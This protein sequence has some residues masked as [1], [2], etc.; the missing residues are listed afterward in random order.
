MKT[1]QALIIKNQFCENLAYVNI[2]RWFFIVKLISTFCTLTLCIPIVWVLIVWGSWANVAQAE[3]EFRFERKWPQLEQPWFFSNPQGIATGPNDE[4]YVASY[5]GNKVDV[6]S[7]SGMFMYSWGTKMTYGGVPFKA[8][9]ITYGPDN[10]IWVGGEGYV[11]IFEKDGTFVKKFGVGYTSTTS[12]PNAF[13]RIYGLEFDSDMHLWLVDSANNRLLVFNVFDVN[14]SLL[15][16]F[17]SLNSFGSSGSGDGQFSSPTGINI[18]GDSV[19]VAERSNK[20]IQVINRLNGTYQKKFLNAIPGVSWGDDAYDVLVDTTDPDQSVW[21]VSNTG[22]KKFSSSG[23]LLSD[24]EGGPWPNQSSRHYYWAPYSIAKTS[25]GRL[26][27]ADSGY[28][29][30]VITDS[31]G[32]LQKTVGSSDVKNGYFWKTTDVATFANGDVVVVDSGNHRLQVFAADGSFKKIIGGYGSSCCGNSNYGKF[33]VPQGVAISPINQHIWVA[34]N[35]NYRI[36]EFDSNGTFL[37]AFTAGASNMGPMGIAI[38]GDG[39]VWSTLT[40]Q[41][42]VVVYNTSG[43]LIASINTLGTDS[44]Y[45]PQKFRNPWGIAVAPNGDIWVTEEYN[46]YWDTHYGL[47]RLRLTADGI[48]VIGKYAAYGISA[49]QTNRARGVTVDNNGLVYVGDTYNHRIQQFDPASETWRILFNKTDVSPMSNEGGFNYLEGLEFDTN[50]MLYVAD[51]DNHRIQIIKPINNPDHS[52]AIVVAAGGTDSSNELWPATQ[53]NANYAYRTFR[54]QGYTKDEIRYLSSNTQQD[55]DFNG[56]MDDIVGLPT[57]VNIENA[58]NTWTTQSDTDNLVLY[59]VDH[60]GDGSFRL[61]NTETLTAAELDGWLDQLETSIQ[62]LQRI[63]IIIDACE[64]GSFIKGSGLATLAGSKR[65]II[66]SAQPLQNA[67]FLTQGTVS[68]SNYFWAHIFHGNDLRSAFDHASE[69]MAAYQVPQVDFNGNGIS[70]EGEDLSLLNNQYIGNGIGASSSAPLIA[71]TQA[72]PAILTATGGSSVIT[73]NITDGDGILD[74]YAIVRSPDFDPGSASQTITELPKIPLRYNSQTQHFESNGYWNTDAQGQYRFNQGAY[75]FNKPGTYVLTLYAEDNNYNAADPKQLTVT[76]DTG[77]HRRA[78]II[79]GYGAGT[80]LSASFRDNAKL[81]HDTLIRQGYSE[82]NIYYLSGSGLPGVDATPTA[83]NVQ[84]A[85]TQ[86]GMD[87]NTDNTEDLAVYLIA[88]RAQLNDQPG[89][90]LSTLDNGNTFESITLSQLALW[91][92][93]RQSSNGF[94]QSTGLPYSGTITV[95]LD[96]CYSGE[97]LATLNPNKQRRI[98]ISSSTPEG[99]AHFTNHTLLSGQTFSTE[100]SFSRV[101]WQKIQHGANLRDAFS[102]AGNAVNLITGVQTPQLDDNFNGL[103]NDAGQLDAQGNVTLAKDGDAARKMS[104]GYGIFAAE[105]QPRILE[106]T[107]SGNIQTL[108][109][110][111][112]MQVAST[113]AISDAWAV[114]TRPDYSP[115]CSA[116]DQLPKLHLSKDSNN[117]A[118]WSAD[119]SK[120]DVNGDYKITFYAIDQNTQQSQPA[121][122]VLNRSAAPEITEGG[123]NSGMLEPNNSLN[124]ASFSLVNDR[125]KTLALE[126]AD[127]QDWIGFYAQQGQT[128]TIEAKNVGADI[129]LGFQLYNDQGQQLKPSVANKVIDAGQRGEREIFDWRAPDYGFYYIKVSNRGQST[130]TDNRFKL[131]IYNPYAPQLGSIKG[132]ITNACNGDK[133]GSVPVKVPNTGYQTYSNRSGSYILSLG[134]ETGGHIY[135]FS[136]DATGYQTQNFNQR[137]WPSKI[138]PKNIK[139]KPDGGCSFPRAKFS[140]SIDPHQDMVNQPSS[141]SLLQQLQTVNALKTR[142]VTLDEQGLVKF[143]IGTKQ[144]L[145]RPVQVTQTDLS[146]TPGIHYSNQGTL[147]I[148]TPTGHSIS[149]ISGIIDKQA[150]EQSLTALDLSVGYTDASNGS[151]L[152]YPNGPADQTHYLTMRPALYSTPATNARQPGLQRLAHT[153]LAKVFLYNMVYVPEGQPGALRQQTFYPMPYNWDALKDY[154]QQQGYQNISLSPKGIVQFDQNQQRHW[155]MMDYTVNRG[156]V[157][158]EL[159]VEAAGDINQDGQYDLSVIYPDGSSQGLFLLPVKPIL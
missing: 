23:Q 155:G 52:K 133:L 45:G 146:T 60:G 6:M 30:V 16:T 152:L 96:A 136:V 158:G 20:R 153:T 44:T 108:T 139:L 25:D 116:Y 132:I 157:D 86:W 140:N 74:A 113:T 8:L 43:T 22:L 38:D 95:I 135:P 1:P 41:S 104:L 129:D 126:T 120:L 62:T 3:V 151:L 42:T 11:F 138:I 66:T 84:F 156:A 106:H 98:L 87:N 83:N 109:V 114:I 13:T 59:L 89:L 54:S 118:H 88:D 145:V 70:N 36:Q 37:N 40:G 68:F 75:P 28:N 64:S 24:T 4:V 33:Y 82:D 47:I 9:G 141:D 143:Q 149:F 119:Y 154:L 103:G 77:K 117:A 26:W 144:Y 57:K 69:V 130:G 35:G 81:A 90:L 21:V 50:G 10:R 80:D 56:Q 102:A 124:Q 121:T 53:L 58:I 5:D 127:D 93:I 112:D 107:P 78:L 73:A 147:E 142:L 67:Y 123:A 7:S 31:S 39:N 125:P 61:G 150:F 92:D 131:D 76:V 79:E 12:N 18:V 97:I 110:Q 134:A 2:N 148:T 55:L 46:T 27:I 34:D 29:Q 63:T 100:L 14:G 32:Q 72:S 105:D 137:L 19:W 101:F 15:D 115:D 111:L 122:A 49:G 48:S 128:Y 91:L 65:R 85:L 17:Q 51:R 99:A 71:S 159:R 94:N